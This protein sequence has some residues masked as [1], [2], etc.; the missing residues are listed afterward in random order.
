MI[1]Q[2]LSS[3][4]SKMKVL[5]RAP[6]V[7]E[8]FAGIGLV[9]LALENEGFK[10]V[11]A[12]DIEP[13]KR[14]MYAANFDTSHFILDDVRNVNGL[15]I[16]S[17][18]LATASFPCTDLSL[19]GNRVGLNGKQSSMFWEF[20]RVIEEMGHRRPA[21][22]MLEN[23]IGF[24][25]SHGGEDVKSAIEKLNELGYRCDMFTMDARRFV[26][27]SRPRLFIIGSRIPLRYQNQKQS[28]WIRPRWIREFIQANLHLDM[29]E[30]SLPTPAQPEG[31]LADCVVRMA[32][33]D[34]RWWDSERFTRFVDSLSP[35]QANRLEFLKC[36]RK[37]AWSTAYRR[38]RYGRAVWEIRPDE[39][40]GCLRT[41]NGGSSRQ[42]VVEAGCGKV[43]VRWM[44]PI[45]YARLQG[46]PDFRLGGVR[47]SEALCGFGD[48]VC[49]PVIAWI[50]RL[51]LRPLLDN[52]HDVVK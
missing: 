38:T 49:V 28:S 30:F 27:Q 41:A 23:V 25:T 22:I 48:A 51:Y 35:L 31:T 3:E 40:S 42:A 45:E 46:A 2:N 17:I 5:G 6:R 26:P 36:R 33:S 52:S 15:D 14:K 12:N 20:A 21:A 8:F 32:S 19:A 1:E 16:P 34:H 39:I 37:L 10:I 29:Q 44:I 7:A 18:D 11:F 13:A 47:E 50:A 24:A 43:R 9:R 4:R